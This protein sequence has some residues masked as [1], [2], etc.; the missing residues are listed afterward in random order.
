MYIALSLIRCY[1]VELFSTYNM[2]FSSELP[3][4]SY[5]KSSGKDWLHF[6]CSAEPSIL[7]A[8]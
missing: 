1:T 8:P 3:N 7:L 5:G 6:V 4:V 2:L